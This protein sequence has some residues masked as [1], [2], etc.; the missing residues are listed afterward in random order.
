MPS[1]HSQYTAEQKHEAL[2]LSDD[3]GVA[4]AAAKLGIPGGTISS[5]R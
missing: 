3:L 2:R 5:G 4:K 1:I